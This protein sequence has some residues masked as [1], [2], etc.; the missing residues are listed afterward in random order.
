MLSAYDSSKQRWNIKK[1]F[2]QLLNHMKDTHLS[3]HITWKRGIMKNW[4]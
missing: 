4:H 1:S 3:F 2:G